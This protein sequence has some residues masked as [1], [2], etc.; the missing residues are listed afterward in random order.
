[1]SV[2]N[3]FD[4]TDPTLANRYLAGQLS[5]AERAAFEAELEAS[6]ATLQELEATA[7]LKV[8]LERLRET[9][10]LEH[11][12]RPTSTTRQIIVGLAASVAVAVIAA[13]FLLGYFRQPASAPLLAATAASF[14]DMQGS[15][16]SI[17]ATVAVFRKRTGDYDAVIRLPPTRNAIEIRVLPQIGAPAE[18]Y[19]V[20]MARMRPDDTLEP[21]QSVADLRPGDDGFV[22][23]FA[24]SARLEPGHY[25]LAVSVQSETQNATGAESFLINIVPDGR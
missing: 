12:L 19:R 3:L 16:L 5:D 11:L 22:S 18:R 14:M 20:S 25:R 8:G 4:D 15:A 2:T 6:G 23:V 21:S 10:E 7:R 17:G 9:G 24:D 1:M 13:S